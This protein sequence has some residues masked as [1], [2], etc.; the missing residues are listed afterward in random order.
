MDDV[1]SAAET[2][3]QGS[4][5]ICGWRRICRSEMRELYKQVMER[6]DVIGAS[7]HEGKRERGVLQASEGNKDR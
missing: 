1:E 2:I 7:V 4:V 5:Y 6:A 3:W